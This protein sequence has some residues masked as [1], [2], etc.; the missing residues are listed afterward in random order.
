MAEDHITLKKSTYNKIMI[1]IV[2]LLV[3]VSFSGGFILGGNGR[4]T[5]GTGT[6][7]Q[8]QQPTQP[9]GNNNNNNRPSTV[10]LNIPS[11]VSFEGSNS[12]KV[13]V[14][15]FGDY[16]CPFCERFY[17]QTEPQI[18]S[19]YI[20]TGKVKFYFMD[21]AFLG[22]DSQTL[23]QGAWC[24]DEQGKYYAYHDYIYSHQGQENSGWATAD[25]VKA[26]VAN[27]Q[28]L[29]TAAFGSC[30]DS[31]K[32]SSR[33]SELTQLGQ[34]VGVSGTPSTLIGNDAKG[35][36]LVVGA[37]PYSV[38]QQAIDKALA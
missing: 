10:S 36:D 35:Y 33:V 1:C 21:F 22:P 20:D 12:A 9:A 31:G 15:E 27:I 37:Q 28:G 26:M 3:A 24:A 2:V 16:Q 19:N 30:L 23:S 5:S 34:S 25:K 32:Y 17:T 29:N 8:Q 4:G 18:S 11:Y 38:L 14:I 7:V 13:N 6:V